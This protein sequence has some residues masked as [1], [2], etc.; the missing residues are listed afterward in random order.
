[1]LSLG[2]IEV[3]QSSPWSSPAVGVMK[4]GI[5]SR[6]AFWQMRPHEASKQKKAFTVP[7]RPLYQF[8]RRR[9]AG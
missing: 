7:N 2:V 6:F 8:I 1:M 5:V 4:P 3:A 9:Y